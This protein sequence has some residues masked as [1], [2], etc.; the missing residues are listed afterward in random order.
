MLTDLFTFTWHGPSHYIRS[1]NG[2]EF[3]AKKVRDRLPRVGVKTLCIER[4]SP[5][6]NGYNESFNGKLQEELLNGEIFYNLTEAKG[7]IEKWRNH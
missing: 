3:T 1:D 6:E 4:G 2:S 5:W 7:L